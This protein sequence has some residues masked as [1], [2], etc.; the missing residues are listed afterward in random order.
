MGIGRGPNWPG[1]AKKERL[2]GLCSVNTRCAFHWNLRR[3]IMVRRMAM[4][5]AVM[6]L[7][8][9]ARAEDAKPIKVLLVLG[10]CCHDYAKQKDVLKK[11]LEER[12]NVEV[13]IAHDPDSTT[14]HLNPVYDNAEWYK[15]FDVIIHDECSSDVKETAIVDSILKPHK[16]GIP[17]VLLHCG[18]HCYRGDGYEKNATAWFEFTGLATK[19]HGA[20]L[21]IAISF[22][23]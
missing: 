12:A 9:V 19:G 15:G 22:V 3:T 23:D 5:V 7:A 14:K 17:G 13:T 10:G 21:P 16:D 18:M 6:M 11:G 8:G 2:P 1:E 4:L 20:Q